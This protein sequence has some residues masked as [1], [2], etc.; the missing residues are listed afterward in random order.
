M[1]GWKKDA[2]R[3]IYISVLGYLNT[4]CLADGLFDVTHYEGSETAKSA[5]RLYERYEG[6]DDGECLL[7]ETVSARG[8]REGK[9][10]LQSADRIISV[11]IMKHQSDISFTLTAKRIDT[12]HAEWNWGMHSVPHIR[13]SD[14]ADHLEVSKDQLTMTE[15][16][17]KE[18]GVKAI[19]VFLCNY[20]HTYFI[21]LK[22]L[23]EVCEPFQELID[24]KEKIVKEIDEEMA[25]KRDA[26]I[27][28][29]GIIVED[30][31]E[32]LLDGVTLED[33][34]GGT[35]HGTAHL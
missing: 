29:M 12:K 3:C 2:I 13:F 17:Y 34:E 14:K 30:G 19:I 10:Y 25:A 9:F 15:K 31:D 8:G 22:K 28:K 32:A 1:E 7:Y 24:K 20:I 6:K 18:Y 23:E 4:A 16:E 35:K 33:S 11:Q 27:R 26:I 21:T 5:Y